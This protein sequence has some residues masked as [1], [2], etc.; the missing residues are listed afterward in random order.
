M[1]KI[2]VCG[3][4]SPEQ[5]SA[6]A[7]LGADAIGLV[8]YPPSSRC[9]SIE[10]A[11]QIISALPPFVQSVALFVNPTVA[12]VEAVL[13]AMPIDLLQ[14]HG[15]ESAAFCQQ[16]QRPYI[17]AFAM[18]EGFDVQAAMAE[19]QQAKG[20][21]LDAY[22]PQKPGG[23]GESFDWQQ[24][25]QQA[26]KPLILAGG[27]HAD[28]IASAIKQCQPY[29]VDVSGGVESAPGQKSLEKVAQFI[30]HTFTD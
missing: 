22:H 8:F 11:Q 21:L 16:F 5:A 13:H 27:L 14:F 1:V 3:L 17:K 28:N 10:Q 29:A 6:V 20:F 4:T 7:R 25:P 23:T 18:K 12:E 15:N 24:F 9:V 26:Q 19:H 2:K 30:R